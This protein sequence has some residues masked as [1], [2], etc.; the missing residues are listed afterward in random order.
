MPI[1]LAQT[2][3]IPDLQKLLNQI[4]Q[5]HQRVRPDLFQDTEQGSKYSEEELKDLLQDASKPIFVYVDDKGQVLGH[6]FLIIKESKD[7]SVSKPLKTLF[8]DD[9]CVSEEVR[10]QKIGQKLFDFA[11]KYAKE[12]GCYDLT[13]NVW[14]DNEGALAFYERQG[15]KARETKMEKIL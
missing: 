3:D 4:F 2:I 6:L 9:L 10:G 7:P 5:V 12:L 1:R 13:L 11:L 8:I 15:L 14:N